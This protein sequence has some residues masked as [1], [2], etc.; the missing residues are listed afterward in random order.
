LGHLINICKLFKT[1]SKGGGNVHS[2]NNKSI[3][4]LERHVCAWFN[5][6]TGFASL[7]YGTLPGGWLQRCLLAA[8]IYSPVYCSNI[9]TH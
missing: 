3:R 6:L 2:V 9:E 7:L 8:V 5:V 1:N 4:I